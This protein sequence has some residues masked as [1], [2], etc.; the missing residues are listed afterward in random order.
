[1]YCTPSSSQPR[2]IRPLNR[3]GDPGTYLYNTRTQ[4]W[5]A[6]AEREFQGNHI[7]GEVINNDLYLFGGLRQGGDAVQ[8]YSLAADE[9]RAG[10]ALPYEVGSAATALINGTVYLCGGILQETGGRRG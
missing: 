6:G 10:A 2:P 1:M 7:G 9:W 4:E 5:S 8:I 3:A